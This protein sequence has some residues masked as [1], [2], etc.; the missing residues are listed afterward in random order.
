MINIV[1]TFPSVQTVL[2]SISFALR[3][4][5]NFDQTDNLQFLAA[6]AHTSSL[7]MKFLP[8]TRDDFLKCTL[9]IISKVHA[10]A[11]EE[12][13]EIEES[14]IQGIEAFAW[15]SFDNALWLAESHITAFFFNELLGQFADQ[16]TSAWF[17]LLSAIYYSLPSFFGVENTD[18]GFISLYQTADEI[19]LD[20][21]S[22]VIDYCLDDEENP[23][24]RHKIISK[25]TLLIEGIVQQRDDIAASVVEIGL[26]EKF[27]FILKCG[28]FKAK[29]DQLNLLYELFVCTGTAGVDLLLDHEVVDIFEG[30]LESEDVDEQERAFQLLSRLLISAEDTELFERLNEIIQNYNEDL[31]D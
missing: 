3:I 31:S 5:C 13:P 30:M 17:S 16:S 11:A 8:K 2:D 23:H 22:S 19:N 10:I 25:I 26:M 4:K 24:W 12:S 29:K 15:H 1:I 28:D 14:C 27:V 6:L 18:S 21:I 9:L 7:C 20:E